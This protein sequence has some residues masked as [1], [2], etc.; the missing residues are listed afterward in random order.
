MTRKIS[1]FLSKKT[2]EDFK[3]SIYDQED[4]KVSIYDQEDLKVSIYDLPLSDCFLALVL[5]CMTLEG[6]LEGRRAQGHEVMQ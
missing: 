1:K 4:F 2:Q 3:V 6:S 5:F